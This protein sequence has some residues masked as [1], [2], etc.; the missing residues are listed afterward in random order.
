MIAE[1][2]ALDGAA[3]DAAGE[4][5]ANASTVP[6]NDMVYT[7]AWEWIFEDATD[8]DDTA[9]GNAAILDEVKVV[10]TVTATQID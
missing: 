9:M 10:I 4:Y 1:I 5:A 6:M 8:A 2:E 3:G 7:I